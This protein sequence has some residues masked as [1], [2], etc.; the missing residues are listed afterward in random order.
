MSHIILKFEI[1][2]NYYNI[3]NFKK[4]YLNVTTKELY[5]ETL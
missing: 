4:S 2:L 1:K 3:P 5:V